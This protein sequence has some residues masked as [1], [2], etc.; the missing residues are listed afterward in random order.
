MLSIFLTHGKNNFFKIYIIGSA[1]S[2]IT[3][4]VFLFSSQRFFPLPLPEIYNSLT[5][6]CIQSLDKIFILSSDLKYADLREKRIFGLTSDLRLTIHLFGSNFLSHSH[7][8][9]RCK[10]CFPIA[11]IFCRKRRDE[12][13][14]P[15]HYQISIKKS[16]ERDLFG[17]ID[18]RLSF[19]VHI[20][21]IS[22]DRIYWRFSVVKFWNSSTRKNFSFRFVVPARPIA[23]W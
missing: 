22:F 5:T 11:C 19:P 10:C 13:D 7:I 14:V 16:H 6:Q 21:T 20:S 1:N 18:V 4:N 3:L 8:Q 17:R 15:T 12:I 9:K 23:V 2:S